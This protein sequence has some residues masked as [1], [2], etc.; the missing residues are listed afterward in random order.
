[1]R[2][3]ATLD[4][5]WKRAPAG[6]GPVVTERPLLRRDFGVRGAKAAVSWELE[7]EEDDAED[8]AAAAGACMVRGDGQVRQTARRLIGELRESVIW[9]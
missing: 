8:G 9:K 5:L 1:M 7:E 2:H 6:D 4:R 3:T